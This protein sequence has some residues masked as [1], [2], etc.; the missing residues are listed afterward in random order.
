LLTGILLLLIFL[1]LAAL[2][3]LDKISALLAVPLMALLFALVARVPLEYILTNI[4]EQG[5]TRLSSAY[6]AAMLGGML[7]LF[8][9]NH[10]IAETMVRYAAELAGDA[11]LFTALAL[12]AVTALLFMT[13]GGLGAVIMVGT[14]TL[15]ILL[16]LGVPPVIAA[17]IMLI[18]ISMGGTMNVSNWQFFMDVLNVPKATVERFSLIL[19]GLYTIIGAAFCAFTLQPQKLARFW[20]RLDDDANRFKRPRLIALLTPVVPLFF[21]LACDWP[22]VPAFLAGLLYGLLTTWHKRSIQTFIKSLFEGVSSVAPAVIL[23]IGIGMLLNSVTHPNIA[24][25]LQ[26]YLLAFVPNT[27]VLFFIVF[28]ALAPLALYRGPLNVWGMGSGFAVILLS[29]KTLSSDAIMSLLISV[30]ALQGACDPTNTH[31]A[32]IAN[33]LNLEPTLILKKLLPWIWALTAGGLLVAATW[34]L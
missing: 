23:M 4:L 34:F 7:A 13:L 8:I 9:K 33:Y 25:A 21:V 15:P 1:L 26:P 5:A 18:G 22:I 16:S 17:G 20:S 12:L 10:G 6:L 27:P 28:L 3:Y 14:I 29:T 11:P 24:N 31:N 19:F 32:W 30:G 2:M